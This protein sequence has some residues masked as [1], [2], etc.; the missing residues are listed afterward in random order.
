MIMR[1]DKSKLRHNG[2]AEAGRNTAT[3][4][5]IT[6]TNP[7][8]IL[9][10]DQRLTK[11][12]LAMY[13]ESVADW[14]MPH[15]IGRPLTLVRCPEGHD[16]ECFYQKHAN[17][18]V[19]ETIDRVQVEEQDGTRATYLMA[20]SISAVVGLAQMGVLEIHTWGSRKDRLDRPDRL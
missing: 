11:R 12:D 17:E 10:P 6:L 13:Y 4:A 14:I 5:R 2:G 7:D 16:E 1:T 9:Y 18:T 20:N 19:P 3:V 8:R 15:L